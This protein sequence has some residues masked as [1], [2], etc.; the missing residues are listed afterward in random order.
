MLV[1]CVPL[2]A[3]ANSSH[4]RFALPSALQ[5]GGKGE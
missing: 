5:Q 2:K 1:Q 3:D 4:V